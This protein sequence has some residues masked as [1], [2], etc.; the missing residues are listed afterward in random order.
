MNRVFKILGLKLENY[1]L[2]SLYP[3]HSGVCPS[4]GIWRKKGLA[5][6]M[7]SRN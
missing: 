2:S 1:N 7:N 4:N 3:G 6:T 5:C